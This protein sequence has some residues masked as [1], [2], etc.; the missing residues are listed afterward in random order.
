M[1][2]ES[3]LTAAHFGYR[4]AGFSTIPV[5]RF[6]KRPLVGVMEFRERRPKDSEI[7]AWV[8]KWP[9]SNLALIMG[10]SGHIALD[11]DG[12]IGP[13]YQALQKF[14]IDLPGDAPVQASGK[15]Y[16]VVMS[17][18]QQVGDAVAWLKEP[19]WQIDV[20]GL[21]YIV[22]APSIH[23]NGR[24]Y[25]WVK[26]L[27]APAPL[28]PKRLVE[29]LVQRERNE[30]QQIF[31]PPPAMN[32]LTELFINGSA[33]GQRNN[34]GCRIAGVFLGLGLSQDWVTQVMYD[35]AARCSP[36]LDYQEIDQIVWSIGRRV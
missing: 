30:R 18:E 34:D 27:K 31:A 11:F 8:K 10:G 22:V 13:A 33:E 3:T 28:A 29:L 26:P 21:G 7:R 25:E 36:P 24:H 2:P 23:Q 12:A 19:G 35:W 6:D 4:D 14:G 32:E 5:T 15:G 20:R 1:I 17:V 9:T 16:H